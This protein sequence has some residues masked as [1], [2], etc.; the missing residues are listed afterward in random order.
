MKERDRQLEETQQELESVKTERIEALAE[1]DAARKQL[2]DAHNLLVLQG[3]LE[4]RNLLI[5]VYRESD[6]IKLNAGNWAFVAGDIGG[7]DTTRAGEA[8]VTYTVI[9]S[10]CIRELEG[11]WPGALGAGLP[12]HSGVDRRVALPAF[13]AEHP[14]TGRLHHS[15]GRSGSHPG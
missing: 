3:D 1:R 12:R 8:S 9:P 11:D 4:E 10:S 13:S 15:A 5:S 14:A 7:L 6:T 2:V